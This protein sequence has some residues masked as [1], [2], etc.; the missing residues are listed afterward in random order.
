M[1]ENETKGYTMPRGIGGIED[2]PRIPTQPGAGD[3][4]PTAQWVIDLLSNGVDT[5]KPLGDGFQSKYTEEI[6]RF[7]STTG[8]YITKP[9]TL[10]AQEYLKAKGYNFIYYPYMAGEVARD[11]APGLRIILKNQLASVGLIDLS[12]TQGSMVDEEFTKGIRRLMEFS[13]NNGGKLD[14]VQSL[15]VL[16]TDMSVRK[17][18]NTKAPVIEGDQMDDIVDELLAKSKARKGAPLSQEERDYITSKINNRIGL[19]NQEIQGLS[20]GTEGRLAFD[21][22][23]PVGGRLIPA[24]PAEEADAEQ[25]A[26]DLA[27]IEEE[28][29]APREEAARVA[30]E[31]EATR[32][33][34]AATIAG[35]TNL[36]RRGVQR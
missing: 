3:A 4:T 27:G 5:N 26:E 15:G 19:F 18:A 8:E 16:R 25:F 28:V 22:S 32:A 11:I 20:A 7:D 1:S 29:F 24:T 23:T 10:D 30:G 21:P 14:W 9:T 12:K 2:A 34:G 31:T 35:L 17:S 33:R 6:T 13:M 36:S